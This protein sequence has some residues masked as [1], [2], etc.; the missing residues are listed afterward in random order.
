LISSRTDLLPDLLPDRFVAPEWRAS[1][2]MAC[3][4]HCV[5][6]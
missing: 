1:R 3:A 2:D 4:T 6:S 5:L